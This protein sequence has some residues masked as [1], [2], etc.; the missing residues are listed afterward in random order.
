LSVSPSKRCVLRPV[1]HLEMHLLRVG[2]CERG[3]IS[4]YS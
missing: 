1:L 4:F 3:C 2:L